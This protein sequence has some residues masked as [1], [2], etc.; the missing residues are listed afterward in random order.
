[1]VGVGDGV[2]IAIWINLQYMGTGVTIGTV[3]SGVLFYMA[4]R[5][6]FDARVTRQQEGLIL[7]SHQAAPRQRLQ[8]SGHGLQFR[9]SWIDYG[10]TVTHV[11][12]QWSWRSLGHRLFGIVHPIAPSTRIFRQ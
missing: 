5:T 11:R 8:R 9:L 12:S 2:K 4:H 7:L 10:A 1:M 6:L 3:K